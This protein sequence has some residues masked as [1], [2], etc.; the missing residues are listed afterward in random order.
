MTFT[1]RTHRLSHIALRHAWRW[2]HI[3]RSCLN[4]KGERRKCPLCLKDHF[5]T[6]RLCQ[7]PTCLLH[8]RVFHLSHHATTKPHKTLQ[9]AG[10]DSTSQ[11]HLVGPSALA[12]VAVSVAVTKAR[13]TKAHTTHRRQSEAAPLRQ[14][15]IARM[16]MVDSAQPNWAPPPPIL[17]HGQPRHRQSTAKKA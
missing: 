14:S 7:S 13:T 1:F 8:S 10:P 9:C 5:N 16:A 12:L 17:S 6:A 3:A 2:W 15:T 4:L 11:L